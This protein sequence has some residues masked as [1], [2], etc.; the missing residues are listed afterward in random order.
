MCVKEKWKRTGV[1]GCSGDLKYPLSLLQLL[2]ELVEGQAV[3]LSHLNQLVFVGFGIFIQSLFKMRH[4]RLTLG[5]AARANINQ[6]V[7]ICQT[8]PH[9]ES[10]SI[11]RPVSVPE[12]LLRGRGV[13]SVLQL[14]LQGLQLLS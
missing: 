2:I 8:H 4:L 1:G 10:V 9:T 3:F 6:L 7:S 12:L 5:P 14:G 13:Q 11:C